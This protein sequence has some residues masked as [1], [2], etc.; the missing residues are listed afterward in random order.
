M[1]APTF[2]RLVCIIFFV[3]HPLFM[4]NHAWPLPSCITSSS[5]PLLVCIWLSS[6]AILIFK[7]KTW[8]QRRRCGGCGGLSSSAGAAHKM[9]WESHSSAPCSSL[10]HDLNA[11]A[12]GR[13]ERA[14]TTATHGL[15]QDYL[16]I[17]KDSV[18]YSCAEPL[19]SNS[20]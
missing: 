3:C 16:L 12:S 4:A 20:L 5:M 9:G 18:P 11:A 10:D 15:K 6:D 2:L 19:P 7:I 13:D 14:P 1:P 17:K 8:E